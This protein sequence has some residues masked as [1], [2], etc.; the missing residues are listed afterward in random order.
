VVLLVV[1]ARIR[2]AWYRARRAVA[3]YDAGLARLRDEWRGTGQQGTRFADEA[4]PYAADLDLFGPGSL[5]ELLCTARTRTGADTLA[6]WLR[7]GAAPGVVRERQP[8]VAEL[9]RMLDLREDLALLG[10]DVPAG[11]DFDAV[12]AWGEGE[13]ILPNHWM[14]WLTLGL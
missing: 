11:V 5:F 6:S 3:F 2:Q 9:S 8:A 10:S 4:H 12:A 13:P 1:Y 14:R 7:A